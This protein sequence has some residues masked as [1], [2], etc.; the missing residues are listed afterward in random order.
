MP[1]LVFAKELEVFWIEEAGVRIE[2]PRHP[3]DRA[4]IDRFVGSNLVGEVLFN[5][6]EH[7]RKGSKALFYIIFRRS[8]GSAHDD[9]VRTSH[10]ESSKQKL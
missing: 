1:L 7:F 2:G 9:W 3:R 6:A 4:L 10:P 5:D 8:G